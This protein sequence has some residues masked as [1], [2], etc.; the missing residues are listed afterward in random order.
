MQAKEPFFPF[1]WTYL[2]V[3]LGALN[4][5]LH[6]VD[7]WACA[8]VLCTITVAMYLHYVTTVV[9]QV[10]LPQWLLCVYVR[11]RVCLLTRACMGSQGH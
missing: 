6:L 1:P 3:G 5:S 7:G 11:A 8:A 2:L 10:S 4:S 9:V